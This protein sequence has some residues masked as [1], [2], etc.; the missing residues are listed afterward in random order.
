MTDHTAVT[1]DHIATLH[2]PVLTAQILQLLSPVLEGEQPTTVIDATLG[3]GGH[4]HAIL[5]AFPNAQVI[6]IDRDP[7]ALQ[8][9]SQRLAPFAD[10]F[11]CVHTTYDRIDTVS[12]QPVDAIL[13]DLGVSS[14]QLDEDERG[15][16]YSR[17]AALDM[18]MDTT[19]TTTAADL[20]N[21]A[22]EDELTRI[23][24]QWGEERFARRIA[25]AIVRERAHQ[26]IENS[27]QL[28]ELVREAIPAATRRHGGHPAKRTFQALRIAVNEELTILERALPAA[29]GSLKIG[30]RLLVESYHSLEDRI[31]KQLFVAGSQDETPLGLPVPLEQDSPPLKLLT[32]KPI[33]ADAEEIATNPRAQSV[34][35]R[36]VQLQKTYP[37]PEPENNYPVRR[38]KR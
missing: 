13:M 23:L 3:M 6:G 11:R 21:Q 15:F 20:V 18:R 14:L 29:L 22:S 31:V 25:Q 38:K 4:S 2:T 16:S 30:G 26:P 37:Q 33:K 7:Q 27:Q 5:S 24:R 35:L 34:R 1:S 36:A 28:A 12:D 17:P 32:R 8:L 19:A 10:R 9:A